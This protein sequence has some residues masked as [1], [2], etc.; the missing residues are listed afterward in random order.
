MAQRE[1]Y[2]SHVDD[3][4][5]KGRTRD[6]IMTPK[7]AYEFRK[8]ERAKYKELDGLVRSRTEVIAVL[9]VLDRFVT[10]VER[11][12]DVMESG[13]VSSTSGTGS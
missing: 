3:D 1:T 9:D 13:S 4:S 7:E 6:G 12:A 2:G 8:D 5:V 10:A 11:I